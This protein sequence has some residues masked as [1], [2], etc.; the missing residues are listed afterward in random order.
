MD[1]FAV[2]RVDADAGAAL[3]LG[4]EAD[5]VAGDLDGAARRSNELGKVALGLG[6]EPGDVGLVERSVVLEEV[7]VVDAAENGAALRSWEK[8]EELAVLSVSRDVRLLEG[9]LVRKVVLDD[10]DVTADGCELGVAAVREEVVLKARAVDD[11]VGGAL[12]TRGERRV[13]GLV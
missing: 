11:E 8:H 5:D 10:E 7:A 6:D 3:A 4:P 9:D 12:G 13:E 1:D 2:C